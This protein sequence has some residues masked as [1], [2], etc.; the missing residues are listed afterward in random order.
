[1]IGPSGR[2]AR[3]QAR[4]AKYENEQARGVAFGHAKR[5]GFWEKSWPAYL[6]VTPTRFCVPAGSPDLNMPVSPRHKM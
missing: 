1:M 2:E 6:A 4:L 5:R 3:L